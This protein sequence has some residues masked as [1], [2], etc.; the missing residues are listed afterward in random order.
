MSRR[1]RSGVNLSLNLAL[2]HPGRRRKMSGMR[3]RGAWTPAEKL[4]AEFGERRLNRVM[5]GVALR[6]LALAVLCLLGSEVLIR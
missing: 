1:G 2:P 4:R 6:L 5:A 3:M